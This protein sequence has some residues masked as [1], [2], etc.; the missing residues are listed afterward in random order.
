M[1]WQDSLGLGA[2]RVDGL[3]ATVPLVDESLSAAA[4]AYSPMKVQ[5]C[6]GEPSD[7]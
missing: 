5:E 3:N 2:V 6:G 1:L 7:Q 4:A